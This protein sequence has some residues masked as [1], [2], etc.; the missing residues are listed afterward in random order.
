MRYQ[1]LI[2]ILAL[3]GCAELAVVNRDYVEPIGADVAR[4]RF[5]A[6][7]GGEIRL[8]PG[9]RCVDWSAPGA[10]IV[11]G[12]VTYVVGKPKWQD[13]KLG[14]GGQ[15]PANTRSSEVLLRAGEPVIMNYSSTRADGNYKYTCQGNLGFVPK[16]GQDYQIGV[17]GCSFFG[18]S[19]TDPTEKVL[20]FKPEEGCAK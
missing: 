11:V 12:N 9:R 5:S 19:L 15:P 2:L 17:L 20:S 10:G 14:I 3:A 18:G 16:A 13:R 6:S 7:E 8:I 1:N 4:V